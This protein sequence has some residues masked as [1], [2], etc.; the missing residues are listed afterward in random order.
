MC[1]IIS[2]SF[3][4]PKYRTVLGLSNS[5]FGPKNLMGFNIN[6]RWQD[7]VDFEGD[8]ASGT[9]NPIHTVDFALLYRLPSIKSQ[10]KLGAN[11]L[12]NQYYTNAIGNP[13]IG[14]YTMWRILLI[15]CKP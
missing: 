9:L 8:F 3:N 13:S 1:L 7:K 5:G 6:W 2:S 10:L 11:N 14:D 12:F 15:Y 4:A